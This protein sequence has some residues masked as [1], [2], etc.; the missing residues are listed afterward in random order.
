MVE[1]TISDWGTKRSNVPTGGGTKEQKKLYNYGRYVTVN[2]LWFPELP[3]AF[4]GEQ[5]RKN[6]KEFTFTK[7]KLVNIS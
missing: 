6:A 3:I 4:Y 2:K 1:I 7:S 5:A